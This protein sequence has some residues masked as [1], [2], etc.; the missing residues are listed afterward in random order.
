METPLETSET[1][2]PAP[3]WWRGFFTGVVL[4][5]WRAW[6]T[7]EQTRA[8]ADWIQHALRLDGPGRLL[9]V[10]CGEGR[11]ARA[12]AERGHWVTGLDQ[13]DDFVREARSR[14][15]VAGPLPSFVRGDMR[16]LPWRGTFDGVICFGSSWGYFDDAGNQAFLESAAAALRPGGRFLL[17]TNKVLEALLPRLVPVA[18][19]SVAGVP[20]RIESRFDPP[21]GVLRADYTFELDGRVERKTLVNRVYGCHE[22]CERLRAAGLAPV[23]LHGDPDGRAFQVGSPR[24]LL[25]AVRRRAV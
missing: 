5:H 22:L 18:R 9:D 17:E 25:A 10:P 8:E 11:L 24:L 3:E 20:V 12:L 7:D 21:S 1:R 19:P 14:A 15:D 2:A 13:A 23:L 6:V 4:D 16:R